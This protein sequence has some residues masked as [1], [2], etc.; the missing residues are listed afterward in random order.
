MENVTMKRRRSYLYLILLVVWICICFLACDTDD[1]ASSRLTVTVNL[2]LPQPAPGRP[3]FI[4]FDEDADGDHTW[5]WM[6]QLGQEEDYSFEF[7]DVP[8][9]TY[10]LVATVFVVSDGT[11]PSIPGDYTGYYLQEGQERGEVFVPNAIV[12]ESG[13]VT[14][15][16]TLWVRTTL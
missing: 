16:V 4:G 14:F 8:P 5:S 9:G 10:Y 1:P 15:N 12:P 3:C 2:T 7:N 11:G 13:S 6:G